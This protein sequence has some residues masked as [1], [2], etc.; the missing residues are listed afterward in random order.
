MRRTLSTRSF[1]FALAAAGVLATSCFQDSCACVTVP[2]TREDRWIG[3]TP[4]RD[5]LELTLVSPVG[6]IGSVGGTGVVRPP[7]GPARSV[8]LEGATDDGVG[9]PS[10]LTITGWFATPVS[11]VRTTVR[12]DS[13]YGTVFLP[14]GIM[15]GDTLGLF[16]R[17]RQ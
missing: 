6:S 1:C 9:G 12:G 17:R 15:P 13:L 10:Q 16:L 14:S 4:L 11:W 5:S 7:A 2:A 8:T 3:L